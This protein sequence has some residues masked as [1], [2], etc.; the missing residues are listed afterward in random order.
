[1]ATHSALG[2]S[3]GCLSSAGIR[4]MHGISSL[5]NVGFRRLKLGP[6]DCKASTW[7][8]FSFSHS[9]VILWRGHILQTWALDQHGKQRLSGLFHLGVCSR[10][11][12]WYKEHLS[13]G[14]VDKPG[15]FIMRKESYFLDFK[16]RNAID[17]SQ[18]W[19]E[20]ESVKNTGRAPSAYFVCFFSSGLAVNQLCMQ[21][22]GHHEEKDHQ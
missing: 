21:I 1:M 9:R 2:S 3:C 5:L 17:L 14:W 20:D 10:V 15:E 22:L 16:G 12:F 11:D 18:C 8:N 7:L 19:L 6:H 4:S 13:R